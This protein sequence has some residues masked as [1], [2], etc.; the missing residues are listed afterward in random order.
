MSSVTTVYLGQYTWDHANEIAGEL[1]SAGI[2]WWVKQPGY[3]SQLW[4]RGVRVFV[5]KTRLAEAREIADRI[6]SAPPS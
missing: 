1:E 5:D 6:L 4:E 2:V 3:L